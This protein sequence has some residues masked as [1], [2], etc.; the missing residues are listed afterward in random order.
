MADG[1]QDVGLDG[2]VFVDGDG[3]AQRLAVDGQ[4]FVVGAMGG[5]PSLQG[6]VELGGVDAYEHVADDGLRGHVVVAVSVSAAEALAGA[7]E[8]R[9]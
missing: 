5:V 6:A 3:V 1:A 8:E 4:R 7:L 2:A 9:S